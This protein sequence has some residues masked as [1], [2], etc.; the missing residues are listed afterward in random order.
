MTQSWVSRSMS[1]ILRR[2]AG[3][4]RSAPSG[5]GGASSTRIPVEWSII[6]DSRMSRSGS[7]P[8]TASSIERFFGFRLSRTPTSPNWRFASTSATRWSV[9]RRIASA[10]FV[11]SVVRPTP[12]FGEKTAMTWW[13]SALPSA[14]PAGGAAASLVACICSRRTSSRSWT[15]LIEVANSSALNGLTRNSRA[16]ASM[17]R[18]RCSASPWTLIMMTGLFGSRCEM[19][20][21]AAMPS[22]P[23]MLMSMTMTSGRISIAIWI[24]SSPELAVPAT[25]ISRSSPRRRDRWSRVS[26][27]SST[28]RTLIMLGLR[29][30]AVGT[31]PTYGAGAPR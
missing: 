19:I 12:P 3:V 21:A 9:S 1:T 30:L 10:R 31:R 22:M 13:S 7:P 25:S 20:S 8:S 2:Y 11:A 17:A 18:L 24:A 14:T 16:P 4:T 29:S 26:G 27:M 23:G 15:R 5:E 28:M 6:T